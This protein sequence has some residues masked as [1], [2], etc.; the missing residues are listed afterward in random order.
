MRKL[1]IFI[2]CF[3]LLAGLFLAASSIADVAGFIPHSQ[4][5]PSLSARVA[6]STPPFLFGAVLLMP[7]RWFVASPRFYFLFGAYCVLIGVAGYR[8]VETLLLVRS[9]Q[10]APAAML[11]AV[12][13]L[14][15]PLLNAAVLWFRWR[16]RT[17]P[18]NS[19]KPKPLR[20]SA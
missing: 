11:V 9:G 7:H 17:P 20:G 13:A 16:S 14:G 15:I 6:S 4:E 1:A 12:P 19:F 10:L 5:M 2:R 8:T 18:N 3:G